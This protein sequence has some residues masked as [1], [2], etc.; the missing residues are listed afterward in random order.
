M[1]SKAELLADANEA[2]SLGDRALALQ[3]LEAADRMPDQEVYDPTEGMSG[4]DRFF[5]GV[6]KG[7]TDLAR[8][9]GQMLGLVDQQTIKEAADRDAALMDTTG[10]MAGNLTGNLAMLL[11]TAFIPG[12]NTLAG[13][14]AIG[15]ASGLLTPVAEDNVA[16]EKAKSAAIGGVLGPASILAGRGL[17]A[18]VNAASGLLEPFRA[19]GQDAIVGRILN[20]FATNADDAARAAGSAASPVPGYQQTLAE[21][22]QD[23]GLATLQRA[24][25]NTDAAAQIG[26][27]DRANVVALKTA[28]SNIAGDDTAKAAAIQARK[29]A[30]APLYTAAKQSTNLAD[31]GRTVRLIDRLLEAN[32]ANKALA[33]PLK[34][35]RETLFES[36]PLQQR[37][38]DAWKVLDD[39]ITGPKKGLPGW[40]EAKQARTIMDRVRKGAIDADEALSQLKGLKT[41]KGKAF[42]EAVDLAKQYIKTPE[43]VL[44]QKP[45]HIMSAL[46]NI[47]A[48]LGKADNAFVRKE[49]LTVKKSLANQLQKA[50]PEYR[51]AEQTFAQMSRPVNQMQIGGLLS[52]KLSPALDDFA[53]TGLLRSAS[54]A[55]ALRRPQQ[56]VQQATGLKRGL[57]D[58]IMEPEQMETIN[59]V[60]TALANRVSAQNMARPVGTNTVQNLS[61]QNLMRQ[62]AGPLGLPE[63]FM[64]SRVWPTLL[65]PVSYAMQAQEPA[66]NQVLADAITDPQLAARL[67]KAGVPKEKLGEAIQYIARY[68]VM[69]A[70]LSTNTAQQ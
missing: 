65:R 57:L 7:M 67:M 11:P 59:N 26:A 58:K 13:S 30:S 55:E 25:M 17:H 10:G 5:T 16:L 63:S 49:L 60:G 48:M 47:D 68:G 21:A 18:G 15:A 64:D 51:A 38:S 42:Q 43:F 28:I 3:L 35:I 36:Y 14:A 29:T 8:G 70:A 56:L 2:L 46:D 33:G 4:T 20:R 24:V 27:A 53:E 41:P 1:A 23:P 9:T 39:V 66:I 61:A 52:D 22:T 45:Q 6:G 32:P 50:A 44:R 54:F 37:G 12:A 34:E 69:P 19:K 40:S 62:I 31:P